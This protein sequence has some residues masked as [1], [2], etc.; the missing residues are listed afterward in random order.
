MA[1]RAYA[2]KAIGHHIL[3][4]FF[5]IFMSDA[6]LGGDRTQLNQ[7]ACVPSH[8]RQW[9]LKLL[10]SRSFDDDFATEARCRQMENR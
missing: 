5:L 2:W 6:A 9:I 10:I 8:L 1:A 3:H 4:R 7:T